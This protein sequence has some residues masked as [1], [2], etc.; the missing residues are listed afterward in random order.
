[1]KKHYE[2]PTIEVME[3]SVEDV[4]TTSS[5]VIPSKGNS[6]DVNWGWGDQ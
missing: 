5:N 3:L 6:T 1:M 2:N 4:I